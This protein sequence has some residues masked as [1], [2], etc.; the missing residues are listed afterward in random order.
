[1]AEETK[2]F[3]ERFFDIALSDEDVESILSGVGMR[4]ARE[5]SAA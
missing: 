1:M 4:A 2:A 3:Y 5:G